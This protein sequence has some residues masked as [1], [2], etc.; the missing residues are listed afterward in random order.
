MTNLMSPV[1]FLSVFVQKKSAKAA[2]VISDRGC[3]SGLIVPERPNLYVEKRKLLRYSCFV[4]EAVMYHMHAIIC[5]P[6]MVLAMVIYGIITVI[7][8]LSLLGTLFTKSTF[9]SPRYVFPIESM[10]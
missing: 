5:T 10:K 7:L 6:P 2:H 1:D 8:L 3:L 4:G 9:P